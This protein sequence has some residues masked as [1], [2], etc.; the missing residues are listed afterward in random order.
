MKPL[1]LADG[2]FVV[3]CYN[4]HMSGNSIGYIK[5]KTGFGEKGYKPGSMIAKMNTKNPA[6][7]QSP[8]V[9]KYI[10][11]INVKKTL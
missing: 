11:K 6:L 1:L 5:G 9:V 3:I 7:K 4:T 8:K 10:N 2:G